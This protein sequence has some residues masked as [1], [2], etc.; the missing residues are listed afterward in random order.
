[1]ANPQPRLTLPRRHRRASNLRAEVRLLPGPLTKSL[2]VRLAGILDASFG[3]GGGTK[4]TIGTADAVVGGVVG[5]GDTITAAGWSGD[6][7]T[8][9][10]Y[11]S[12]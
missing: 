2:A 4:M 1:M 8:V 12:H 11:L 9:A 3:T 6:D 5:P 10:R 7:L